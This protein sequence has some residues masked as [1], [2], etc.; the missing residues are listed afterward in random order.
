MELQDKVAIVGGASRGIGKAIAKAYGKEGAK[1]VVVARTDE[2]GTGP[3]GLP[4]TIHQTVNE[5]QEAGGEA[6]AV[7]CDITDEDQVQN[8]VKTVLDAYGRVDILVNN[9]AV[10]L[11]TE[12]KDTETRRWNLM[13]RVNVLG[14]FLLC[15]YVAPVMES[16]RGG[17]I[18]NVTSGGYGS[19]G[20]G[21][22]H[23]SV[24]KACLEQMTFSLA[25]EEREYGIAVNAWHPGSVLTEGVRATRPDDYD[26][27]R[28]DPME[29][30]G[31]STVYLAKQTAE[32]LT[33]QK[34]LRTE[35]GETWP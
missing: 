2:E 16:Q 30:V 31:P 10:Q 5:I 6:I 15:K 20:K 17:S 13:Q 18:I 27:S 25:E 24:S 9:A 32:T 23:Y 34:V 26:F 1:V 35:Y 12:L 22:V 11:R 3:L 19:K 33:G 7:K 14:P 29:A 21:G 8:L 28:Y 4:G